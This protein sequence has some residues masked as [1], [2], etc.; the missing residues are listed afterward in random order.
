MIYDKRKN[1]FKGFF[2][3][4]N[5]LPNDR[6][7]ITNLQRQHI[8]WDLLNHNRLSRKHLLKGYRWYFTWKL[9]WL[10]HMLILFSSN[11][12]YL[13]WMQGGSIRRNMPK[14]NL[15]V[16][17]LDINVFREWEYDNNL[18]RCINNKNDMFEQKDE[19]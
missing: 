12:S 11:S 17:F 4:R 13:E 3:D 18:L 9:L 1:R 7:L 15:H 2:I 10:E 5:C 19:C 6:S 14:W 8:M 16:K